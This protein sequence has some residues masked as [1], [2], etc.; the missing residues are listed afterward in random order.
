MNHKVSQ[1]ITQRDH[2]GITKEHFKFILKIQNLQ[3][4]QPAGL[5]IERCCGITTPSFVTSSVKSFG[6]SVVKFF[7]ASPLS[8]RASS[9]VAQHYPA[10]HIPC[11][12]STSNITHHTLRHPH[13][14]NPCRS[15]HRIK[16]HI[17]HNS[18]FSPAGHG[19]FV[20]VVQC[21]PELVILTLVSHYLD[22]LHFNLKERDER[23]Q[24]TSLFRQQGGISKQLFRG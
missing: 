18:I 13:G 1:R 8:R 16:Y 3:S 4:F 6:S 23:I 20:P 7:V 17:S 9:P 14:L 19:V 12:G 24:F 15:V 5:A 2:K 11:R 21:Y 10:C 22:L